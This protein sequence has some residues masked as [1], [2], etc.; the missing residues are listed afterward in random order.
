MYDEYGKFLG[1]TGRWRIQ[2]RTGK[3]V[4]MLECLYGIWKS[5]LFRKPLPL[6]S[7]KVW[8]DES[9]ISWTVNGDIQNCNN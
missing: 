4:M 2:E 6:R 9:D 8:L 1:F 7:E 3:K 5:R